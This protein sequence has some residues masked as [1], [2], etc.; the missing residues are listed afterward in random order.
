MK[1]GFPWQPPSKKS[2]QPP[3]TGNFLRVPALVGRRGEVGWD[4]RCE[5]YFTTA[6]CFPNMEAKKSCHSPLP[7][8]SYSL[9]QAPFLPCASSKFTVLTCIM[10]TSL[11][12]AIGDDFADS[13]FFL[14]LLTE[15]GHIPHPYK[16]QPAFSKS[17][18]DNTKASD[19]PEKGL[20][21][22]A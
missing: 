17:Q 10:Y 2:R 21:H 5:K 18:L 22:E 20:R 19:R 9:P 16:Y 4:T 14:R 8:V 11:C 13:I 6:C 15:E 1:Q 7:Y 3:P 12:L